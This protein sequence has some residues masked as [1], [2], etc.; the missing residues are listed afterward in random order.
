MVIVDSVGDDGGS[1]GYSTGERIVGC[2]IYRL[3]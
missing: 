2:D 3:E 1:G